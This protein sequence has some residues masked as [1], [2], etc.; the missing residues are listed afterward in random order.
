MKQDV[1]FSWRRVNGLFLALI[2]GSAFL[3]GC[4]SQPV[5]QTL[6]PKWDKYEITIGSTVFYTNAPNQATLKA[7]FTSPVGEKQTV[8][9]FWDGSL[10][11]RIRF[12][13]DQAGPWRYETECSDNTNLGLHKRTGAFLCTA[14]RHQTAFT[15]HGPVRV[16]RSGRHLEHRDGTPFFWL[17]DTAWNGP[18][19]SNPED[20]Q[21]YL[22]QRATQKFTAV[23]W[24]TTQ[25]RAAPDGDAKGLPAYTGNQVID[26]NP[27][28]FQ[29]LDQKVDAMN[30][31]GLLSVPVMLWA[32]NGGSNPRINPGVSL[33]EDQAII[34]CRYMVARWGANQVTWILNGDGDYR[35]DKAEKWRRIGRAVFGSL[36]HAPVTVHP[37]GRM[38]VWNE[39]KNEAWMDFYGYQ[40]GH[41]TGADNLR[42]MTMGPATRDWNSEP[43]KPFISLEA[44]YENHGPRDQ[45]ITSDEVRRAHYWSLLANPT[46]GI[47]YGGHG[48]WGWDDGTRT[49]TDHPYTGVPLPWRQALQMPA[50]RQ[51]TL[52]A[53]FFSGIDFW[54]LRP[55]PELVARQ[56]GLQDPRLFISVSR[57]PEKDLVVA[58]VPN[59]GMVE[60]QLS[61]LT[62]MPGSPTIN[63]FNP[64]TGERRPAVAVLGTTTVMIPTV[65]AGDW[66][67]VIQPG[68]SG[69]K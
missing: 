66:V 17:A 64:R 6:V 56:P 10:T 37:G 25:W 12:A 2:A 27:E 65:A 1:W 22:L 35:G 67:M 36:P 53:N 34:L 69:T 5:K 11:W 52:A 29:R 28:F 49:P 15:T 26:I 57:S 50:A 59:E 16:A 21:Y 44:P 46:A 23:Q 38:W 32:I 31:A 51:M 9:G 42:W 48:I 8:L 30:K 63:W 20:W 68:R 58:Y 40:S 4:V 33:P 7:T 43:A 19:V 61:V 47:T 55:A 45:A 60:L 24:V 13:P 3:T 14:P 62:D 54:R 39:F 18:L 41:S